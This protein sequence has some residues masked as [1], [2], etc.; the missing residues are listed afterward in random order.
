[1]H[2]IHTLKQI[3]DSLLNSG[4]KVEFYMSRNCMFLS[5][6]FLRKLLIR[7]CILRVLVRL[8]V[9]TGYAL[10]YIGNRNVYIVMMPR[11]QLQHLKYSS[12]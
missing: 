1:M 4:R 9:C 12:N 2:V 7:S 6:L 10:Y 11:K 8:S 3:S 5:P